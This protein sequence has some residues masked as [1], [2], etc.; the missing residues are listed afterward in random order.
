MALSNYAKSGTINFWV[1]NQSV[2]Q[3]GQCFVALYSTN[4]TGADTGTEVS[5]GGYARQPVTFGAPTISGGQAISQNTAVINF[6][7]LTASAGTAAY[8]ALKDAENGGNLIAYAALPASLQL[9]AGFQP[10]I[11]IG[12]LRVIAT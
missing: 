10:F 12:D 9:N 6:P 3:P 7:Q 2:A 11:A 1:R 8:I 4:P 5:G